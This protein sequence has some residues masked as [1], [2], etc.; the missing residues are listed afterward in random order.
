MCSVAEQKMEQYPLDSPLLFLYLSFFILVLSPCSSSLPFTL[1]F[2]IQLFVLSSFFFSMSLFVPVSLLF[3]FRTLQSMTCG[4]P[5]GWLLD[6]RLPWWLSC[7]FMARLGSWDPTLTSS[8]VCVCVCISPWTRCAIICKDEC[9]VRWSNCALYLCITPSWSRVI[10]HHQG[11]C[12]H[13][14]ASA[15]SVHIALKSSFP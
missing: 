4:E 5:A 1:S 12:I 9:T 13:F 3:P 10:L 8:F 2:L 11:Y 15:A 6:E 7:W 14:L